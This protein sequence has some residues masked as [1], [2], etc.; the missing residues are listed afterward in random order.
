MFS[1]LQRNAALAAPLIVML[2]ASGCTAAGEEAPEEGAA[3]APATVQVS[4][5]EF[6]IS[7]PMIRASAGEPLTFEVTNKGT[8]PHTF[9][10]D[11]GEVVLATA[12]IPPAESATLEV[13]ALQAGT[14]ET[15]CTISGHKEA[16]WWGR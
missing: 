8:A 6:A 16:A 10:I 9:A 14:Y 12:E 1:R 7:P 11:T 13:S 4:L 3:S 15:F 2:A 5:T